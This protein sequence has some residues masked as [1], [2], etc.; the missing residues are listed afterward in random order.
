MHDWWDV[1]ISG[2][3][4]CMSGAKNWIMVIRNIT[5]SMG[6]SNKTVLNINNKKLWKPWVL[7]INALKLSW[8]PMNK[9]QALLVL[10]RDDLLQQLLA[11]LAGQGVAVPL[12]PQLEDAGDVLVTKPLGLGEG[13]EAPPVHWP[14]LHPALVQQEGH[15]VLVTLRSCQVKR[16]PPVIVTSLQWIP[17]EL[18]FVF[19]N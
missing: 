13:G 9:R 14:R 5:H 3:C 6:S 7:W 4:E 17:C 16:G 2:T 1:H 11:W 10:S 18:L 15:A 12:A 8:K 19:K